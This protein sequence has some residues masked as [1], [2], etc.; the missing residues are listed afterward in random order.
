LAKRKTTWKP[1]PARYTTG[2]LGKYARLVGTSAK[3]AVCN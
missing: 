3:G 2:V 1:A